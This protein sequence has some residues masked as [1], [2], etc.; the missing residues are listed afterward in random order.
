MT[1]VGG[2]TVMRFVP[3][4]TEV[5]DPARVRPRVNNTLTAGSPAPDAWPDDLQ[6]SVA[7]PNPGPAQ[8]APA[9][10]HL[11]VPQAQAEAVEPSPA[12]LPTDAAQIDA[13]AEQVWQR[14][15]ARVQQRIEAAS[16]QLLARLVGDDLPTL[17]AHLRAQALELVREALRAEATFK[18]PA[19][20]GDYPD[21][22][23]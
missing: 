15:Q 3:T 22:M 20:T 7:A 19:A 13:M 6:A 16:D 11:V 4:L 23:A 8:S 21:R 9:L 1:P 10:A 2:R 5:V 17:T 14:V 12:P 18:I